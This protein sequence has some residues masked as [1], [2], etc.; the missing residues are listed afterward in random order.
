M[1]DDKPIFDAIRR[2]FGPLTTANVRA[3]QAGIAQALTAKR[4]LTTGDAAIKL[5]HEF[6]GFA[7]VLPNGMVGAY[8][9]PGTGGAPWTIGFGS[10][11]DEEGRPLNRNTVW[12]R[13]R[14]EE[15]FK[16]DLKRFEHD[17]NTLLGN[18][19]TTQNQFDALMSFIY[20]VGAANVAKSTL[21]RKHIAGDYKGAAKEFAR[22][23]RANGRVLAGLI[24]RRAAEAALYSK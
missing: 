1:I 22:Y 13:Q 20:N 12:T 6:E 3:I 15:R 5:M 8:P 9:D 18:S 16:I 23:N 4:G 21:L 14:A 17:L 24:R 2:E 10:T 11:T 7:K 19:L